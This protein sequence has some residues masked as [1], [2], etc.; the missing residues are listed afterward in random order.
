MDDHDGFAEYLKG[1]DLF[2]KF[3]K[4]LIVD[5]RFDESENNILYPPCIESLRNSCEDPCKLCFASQINKN[6]S[7]SHKI[8]FDLY[9]SS[10]DDQVILL[11]R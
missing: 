10:C 3:I 2:Y 7:S 4:S 5:F 1:L 8:V 11:L 6:F 9:S